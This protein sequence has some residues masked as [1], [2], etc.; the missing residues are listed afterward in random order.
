MGDQQLPAGDIYGMSFAVY[1]DNE[2][3]RKGYMVNTFLKKT[4]RGLYTISNY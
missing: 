2:N 3:D 4:E 1:N